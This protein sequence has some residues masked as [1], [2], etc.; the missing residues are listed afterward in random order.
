MLARR[1]DRG[2]R[3]ARRSA[4]LCAGGPTASWREDAGTTLRPAGAIAWSTTRPSA[5]TGGL[6]SGGVPFGLPGDQ[7][8]DEA[9]RWSTR[10]DRS[11]PT[12]AI[13]GRPRAIVHLRR[14]RRGHR[15]RGRACPMSLPTARSHL[16]AKG[17]LNGTRR[18][19]LTDP[20]PL[21]PG[22]LAELTIDIDA[23]GWRFL[24]GHRIRVAIAAADWP[25]VWPTP[26]TGTLDVW[27][28]AGP[29]A[30]GSSCRSCPASGRRAAS[31]VPAVAGRRAARGG[32]FDR[33][34][35]GRVSRGPA[36][37]A[38]DRRGWEL[39]TPASDARRAP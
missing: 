3:R 31:V 34:R 10:R 1:D 28:G 7:R 39:E 4:T 14:Q 37:R 5:T 21:A 26:E 20:E 12:V 38:R 23:T 18:D 16:V 30:R 2:R 25:N 17:M 36:D 6:W 32:R 9:R 22:E 11:T 29:T 33:P 35:P 8:P 24:A 15:R 13:L 19:S 27:H